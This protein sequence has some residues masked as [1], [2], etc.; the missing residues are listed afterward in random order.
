ATNFVLAQCFNV[1]F[2]E[3]KELQI[4]IQ[5]FT[6][7]L[8]DTNVIIKNIY[9]HSIPEQFNNIITGIAEHYASIAKR[10]TEQPEEIF[11]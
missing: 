3:N 1:L 4:D 5:E 10:L 9:R 2:E 6:L 11:I 7:Y 8:M